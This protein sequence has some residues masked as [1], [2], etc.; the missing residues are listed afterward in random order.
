[1]SFSGTKYVSWLSQSLFLQQGEDV[2]LPE[3]PSEPIP[4]VSEAAKAEPGTSNLSLNKS[5]LNN[6][7]LV[8]DA[9]LFYFDFVF[10]REARSKEQARQRAV[11]SLVD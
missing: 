1:M 4:E 3:V 6:H 9:T 10:S 5:F 8:F 11:G 7:K 2:A